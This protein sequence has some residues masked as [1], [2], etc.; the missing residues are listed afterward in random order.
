MRAELAYFPGS[1]FARMG[2]VLIAEWG[3]AVKPVEW[4]FPPPVELFALNPLGQVPALLFGDEAV[5]PTFMIL[6]RLWEMAGWPDEGYRPGAER[7]M[8]LTTLQ[9]GDA[10]A[11]AFYQDW[12][13]L[14]P[15]A[16]N[17][18]G[19]D[20]AARNLERFARTLDWLE[21]RAAKGVLRPGITLPGVAAACLLL[22]SEARGGPYWAGRPHLWSIV[23]A[24]AG[25][26][27]FHATVPQSWA[28]V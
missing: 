2:R 10:L 3:L 28:P 13:G 12:S 16:E 18:V 24:L 21:A 26:D 9:A 25:R 20:P 19:F 11:A 8:L 6:E 1:P 22:W 17:H 15:V 23:R 27:S 5:F 4:R 7:Q 14:R